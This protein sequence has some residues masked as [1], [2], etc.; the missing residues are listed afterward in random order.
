MKRTLGAAAVLVLALCVP[1]A[2]AK[3]QRTPH[4]VMTVHVLTLTQQEARKGGVLRVELWSKRD[5]DVRV[6]GY[7]LGKP[8]HLV[9]PTTVVD[10]PAGKRVNYPLRLSGKGR[11]R[12]GK[13]CYG[14]T[15][16]VVV[17]RGR[18]RKRIHADR[19]LPAARGCE[20][21]A[22]RVPPPNSPGPI[23]T[24]SVG[25]ASRSIDP[26]PDGKWKGKNV[27]LGG[28]G[29]SGGQPDGLDQGRAAD[30][31]LAGGPSVT[32]LALSDGKH[33]FAFATIEVQGWFVANKDA[34]YGLVDMRKEVAKETGGA[35]KADQ[36]LI[37]SDHTHGGA[38]PMGVWGGVPLSFRKFMFD[39]TVAA[40]VDAWQ[41]RTPANLYYGW[42]PARDL[43][44]NQ[45]DYDASN[46]VM[47]SDL[48]VLQA[49]KSDGTPVATILDYSAHPTVLGSSNQHITGDWPQEAN[50][51]MAERFGGKALTIV[52]TLGRTQPADRSCPTSTKSDSDPDEAACKLDHYA[53]RV[54]DRVSQALEN[55]TL[56][57]GP[58]AISAKSYLIQDPAHNAVLLGF[59]AVGDP[60]GIPLNRSLTPPW[61]TGNVLG[62]VTGSVRIGDVLLST[63]PGEIYPQIALKVA[64]S[65]TGPVRK[66]GF[67]TAGLANDQLGYI[68]Y[69]YEAY[70]EPIMATFVSR[71]DQLPTPDPIGND[72]YA[73]NVSHTL[74]ARVTC[75]LLRGAGE[76]FG[77]GLKYRSADPECVQ[78]PNDTL[79]SEGMDVSFPAP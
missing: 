29:I 46:K 55:A 1:G 21:P 43:Q 18:K 58:P 23:H 10:L 30:G 70:P 57:A 44:S 40:I 49:R 52:G 15:V 62:T 48:R 61:L 77:S 56:L 32:A 45:F 7:V 16:R 19:M 4:A 76:A 63:V 75:S 47:D 79:Y 71:G 38:D 69:P 73:F 39:Q 26:D 12:F 50:K 25:L 54:V 27:Y 42:A 22:P 3:P 67:M 31:I 13:S 74:G 41:H 24:Y 36:V 17:V 9:A 66:H 34:P 35:L 6:R 8:P 72:N 78:F 51:L 28:Y 64:D 65:L 60:I 59:G 20:V 14:L 2:A 11:R 37:Q 68:I 33:P 5:I 53:G